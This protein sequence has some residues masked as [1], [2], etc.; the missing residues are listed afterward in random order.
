M[1]VLIRG[2]SGI[3][4]GIIRIFPVASVCQ[5]KDHR[6]QDEYELPLPTKSHVNIDEGSVLIKVRQMEG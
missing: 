3:S 4:G 5:V 1:Y 2:P 6:R